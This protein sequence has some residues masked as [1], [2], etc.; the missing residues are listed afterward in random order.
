MLTSIA[1]TS[2][3]FSLAPAP[4]PACKQWHKIMTGVQT[5]LCTHSA[6]IYAAQLVCAQ[7]DTKA[8]VIAVAV[9]TSG[10]KAEKMIEQES[11]EI[12]SL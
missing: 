6:S 11:E 9:P 8:L 3:E 7:F 12:G 10:L 5:E 4:A 1:G 2:M